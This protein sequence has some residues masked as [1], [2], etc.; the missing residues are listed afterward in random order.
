MTFTPEFNA[1]AAVY[2]GVSEMHAVHGHTMV[3][4]EDG[5]THDLGELNEY[6]LQLSLSGLTVSVNQ[7]QLVIETDGEESPITPVEGE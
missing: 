7:K 4:Y 1:I 3:T 2:F 5:T 6:P